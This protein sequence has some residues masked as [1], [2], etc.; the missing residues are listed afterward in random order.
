MYFFSRF[1]TFEVRHKKLP[2]N[3]QDMEFCPFQTQI[4]FK[5]QKE[6][7]LMYAYTF[8]CI[9]YVRRKLHFSQTL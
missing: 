4:I 6:Q 5:L 1:Y 2:R 3:N 8:I 9:M 7:F